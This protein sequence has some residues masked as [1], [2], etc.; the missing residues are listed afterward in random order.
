MPK[1][2]F[3]TGNIRQNILLV[4]ITLTKSSLIIVRAQKGNHCGYGVHSIPLGGRV[5]MSEGEKVRE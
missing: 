5:T 3:M 4:S 1:I 2:T